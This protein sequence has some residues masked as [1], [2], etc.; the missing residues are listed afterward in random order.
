[1]YRK[2]KPAAA[3]SSSP[4]PQTIPFTAASAVSSAAPSCDRAFCSHHV[5]AVGGDALDLSEEVRP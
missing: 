3:T 2:T 4:R 5:P 1:M